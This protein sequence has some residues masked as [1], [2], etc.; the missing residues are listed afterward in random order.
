MGAGRAPRRQ[1]VTVR[2]TGLGERGWRRGG[3]GG[4]VCRRAWGEAWVGR[5]GG[6]CRFVPPAWEP[7]GSSPTSPPRPSPLFFFSCRSSFNLYFFP[8]CKSSW[9]YIHIYF[10]PRRKSALQVKIQWGHMCIFPPTVD[11]SIF[12]TGSLNF[13]FRTISFPFLPS[14]R[15]R[16]QG[17]SCTASC[18]KI[19]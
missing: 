17:L 12:E 15:R 2:V 16:V 7:G 6:A 4:G 11:S 3:G 1:V 5:G 10:A 18:M 14:Y 8:C 13:L 9:V 19:I